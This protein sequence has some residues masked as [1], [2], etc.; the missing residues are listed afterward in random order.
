LHKINIDIR[1]AN[2]IDKR[3]AHIDYHNGTPATA[4]SDGGEATNHAATHNWG[5]PMNSILKLFDRA[6]VAI[7]AIVAVAVM[8]L[9][10]G[11]IAITL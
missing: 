4:V 9:A 5:Y 11:L 8:P 3:Y 2:L 6:G 1:Y 7:M 10:A